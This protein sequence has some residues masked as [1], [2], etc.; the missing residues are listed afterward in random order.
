M[1]GFPPPPAEDLTRNVMLVER[2]RV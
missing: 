2:W 1:P